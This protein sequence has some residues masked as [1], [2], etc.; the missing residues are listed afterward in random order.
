MIQ[1]EIIP[2]RLQCLTLNDVFSDASESA[3]LNAC[4]RIFVGATF[5]KLHNMK[6]L[7]CLINNKLIQKPNK[8]KQTHSSEKESYGSNLYN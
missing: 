4:L 2:G 1:I 5:N 7:F 8:I 3:F 6:F